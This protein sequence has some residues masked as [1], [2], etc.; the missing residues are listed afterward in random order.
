MPFWRRR[1]LHER[2]ARE[3][4]LLPTEGPKAPWHEVGIHGV[5]RLR[6]FDASTVVDAPGI[7]DDEVEFVVLPDGSLLIEEEAGRESDLRPFADALDAQLS[8]PYRAR[9]TRQ[10]DDR[11]ALG[12]NRIEV[13]E[14]PEDVGGDEI[15]VAVREGRTTLVVDHERAWGGRPE[16]ER[17][18]YAR[19][20]AD[21]VVHA[22]RLDGPLWE[23]RVTPL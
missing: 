19:G 2:L 8:P 3:G 1:P 7:D 5:P 22:E 13:V 11:W 4:G 23:V 20:F 10:G 12:A 17:L 9:G 18:G 21:F 14:L 16:L 15:D 6:E